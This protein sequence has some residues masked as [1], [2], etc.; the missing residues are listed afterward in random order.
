MTAPTSSETAHRV[1]SYFGDAGP[2]SYQ[3]VRRLTPVLLEGSLPYDVAVAGLRKI[4]F[5]LARTCNLDVAS[6]VAKCPQFRAKNFYPLSRVQYAIDRQFAV[7]L[8]PETV[9]SVDGVPNLIF[10]Q[11]RKNPTPWAYNSSFLRRILEESYIPDYF[12]QARFWLVD[13]EADDEGERALNLVDLQTVAP[14]ADREFLRR[15]ALLRAAWRLHLLHVEKKPRRPSK[16]DDR[17]DD[18]DLD[19]E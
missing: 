19:D 10:L 16:P 15:I 18:L 11:P 17:Q 2:F 3:K 7:S 6:L 4:K 5:D 9:C 13:T 1:S 8:R 14:M 12:D